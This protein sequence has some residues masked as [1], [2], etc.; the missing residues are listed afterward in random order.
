MTT[1]INYLTTLESLVVTIDGKLYTVAKSAA[2]FMRL[3][4]ALDAGDV[5]A[6]RR[7][8]TVG[9]SL[10]S[11][12]VGCEG[13]TVSSDGKLL[14]RGREVDAAVAKRANDMAAAGED[15]RRL[16]RFCERLEKNPSW[17]SVQQLYKFLGHCGIPIEEDGT[18]LAYKGVTAALKDKHTR[19]FDNSPGQRHQMPRNLVSDDPD[20]DCHFGF[21]VGALAYAESFGE[22]VVVCRVD[23]E[24]VV[25]VPKD[26]ECQKMRVCEYVVV[27]HHNGELMPSTSVGR[28]EMPGGGDDGDDDDDDFD[29]DDL[30]V[31]D[32]DEAGKEEAEPAPVPAVVAS[33]AKTAPDLSKIPRKYRKYAT[34]EPSALMALPITE[35]RDVAQHGFQVV[36]AKLGGGKVVL[37]DLIL[38]IREDIG[39]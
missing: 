6:A 12:L 4:A 3:K 10:A 14:H 31:V 36:G 21:H 26:C 13:F 37:V 9:K 22:R 8:L 17:R 33:P 39:C 7:N 20:V 11:W 2:N 34:M 29:S 15:P 35:L 16:L 38:T 18:F 5:E 32:D 27:G 24:H 1:P 28:D 25:S 30:D 19:K 23:P